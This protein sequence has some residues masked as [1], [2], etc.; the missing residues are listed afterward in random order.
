MKLKDFVSLVANGGKIIS[1]A[2]C[3]N[4]EI[5]IARACNRMFVDENGFGYIYVPDPEKE[6][7]KVKFETN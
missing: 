1:S 7:S 3:T 5:S 4:Y 2:D 6:N